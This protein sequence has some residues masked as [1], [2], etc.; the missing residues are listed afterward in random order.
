MARRTLA[1]LDPI[2]CFA[3]LMN[4]SINSLTH[5]GR[6]HQPGPRRITWRCLPSRPSTAHRLKVRRDGFLPRRETNRSAARARGISF[7]WWLVDMPAA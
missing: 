7:C 3:G 2:G 5:S 1:F 4:E 6:V